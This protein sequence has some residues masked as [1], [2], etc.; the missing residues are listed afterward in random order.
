MWE[1]A[2]TFV[3]QEAWEGSCGAVLGL[4]APD[5]DVGE[6]AAFGERVSLVSPISWKHGT[7]IQTLR[8]DIDGCGVGVGFGRAWT[9][10]W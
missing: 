7:V 4:L 8:A 9:V 1:R 5:E 3:H 6:L 2:A 10:G